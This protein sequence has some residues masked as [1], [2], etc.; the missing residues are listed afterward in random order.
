MKTNMA[1]AVGEAPVPETLLEVGVAGRRYRTP[2]LFCVLALVLIVDLHGIRRGEFDFNVDEAQHGVTGLFVADALHDLPFRHPVEYAYRY[3]AQYPAIAI[4]HWPPLFYV[5]EGL[6]FLTMGPTVVAARAAVLLFSLLLCYQ[7]FGLVEEMQ[8]VRTAAISTGMLALLPMMVLFEK[9]VM[10]EIPSLALSIAAIRAWIG[11]MEKGERASLY[12]FALWFSAAMLCKQTSVFIPVFCIFSLLATRRWERL[13]GRDVL[14]AAALVGLLVGPFYF[15]M[16]VSQGASVA[17]D[18]GSHQMS[19]LQRFFFYWKVLPFTFTMPM[20]ALSGLGLILARR[21]NSK[22]QILLMVSWILAGYFTFTFFGQK[23]GRFTI[24]WF[25]PLVYFAAGLLMRGFRIPVLRTAMRFAAMVIVGILGVRAWSYE[26]PYIS[27]YEMAAKTLVQTYHSGI[28]LFDGKVPG[29]FVFYMRAVDPRRQFLVLRK[30]LYVS[31]VRKNQNSEELVTSREDL[32][33]LFKEDGIRFVVVSENTPLEF[34]SQVTL[35]ECLQ[36]DQFRLIARFPIQG[37]EPVWHG[38]ALLLYEN[39]Q[40][41]PPQGK[42]LRL[43]M[44]ALNHDIVVPLDQFD[45]VHD[46][47]PTAPAGTQ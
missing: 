25:P 36:S 24:Y 47:N 6:S 1:V 26:R 18:L 10:L 32:L 17:Q 3:Y 2:L 19:G 20:A 40:W 39:K 11:Y 28:V 43:R 33:N 44:L 15:L 46:Q 37:N 34:R 31:D 4:V 35:R 30:S 38:R 8:D 27:G 12:K 45:F 16:L 22:A 41:V 7:W 21:W 29:N 13:W 23:E 42:F 9:T 5:F 14:I